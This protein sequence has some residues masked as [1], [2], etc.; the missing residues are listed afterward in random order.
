[1]NA[2]NWSRVLGPKGYRMSVALVGG[3]LVACTPPAMV[4][5]TA[6]APPTP[7]AVWQAP[8]D[9]VQPVPAPGRTS[10]FAAPAPLN[11]SKMGALLLGD[12]VELALSNSPQTRAS[13]AQARERLA[14]AAW[15][16]WAQARAASASYG[17]SRGRL[18]PSASFDVTGGPSQSV[19]QNPAR[20]P[21][22][23]TLTT[24]TLSL[25]Y[26][27][28]DFG[29]RGG[30]IGAA[31]EALYAAGLN[32]NAAVQSVVLQAEGAYFTY[33]S[34]R[35][36]LDAARA[37]VQ[38]AETNLA[39]AERRHDVG[40]ATIADVLQARTALAQSQLA[41]QTAEGNVQGARAQLALALGM[42]ANAAFDVAPDTAAIG[43]VTVAE[44]VDSLI[45]RAVRDRPDVAAAR[46]LARQSEQQIRVVRSASL[47][48]VTFGANSGKAMSNAPALEGRTLA[49]TLGL[50]VPLFNGV[51]RELDLVAAQ[52][53]FAAAVA[54]ADQARLQAV[55]QVFTSYWALRTA[56]Q[57]V[58]TAANLL[59]SA[60]QS[61]EVARG[62]YAEGVGSILDLL[63]AQNA[64][65]DA[66]AQAVQ[67]RWTWFTA[68]AQLSRDAG[69]LG[70]A[71]ETHL[72][73]TPAVPGSPE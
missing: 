55:A 15:S 59:A 25:Q 5:G 58:T 32:H 39:A 34:S 63:S 21:A 10:R 61:E 11:A 9:A 1:M 14:I 29:A 2:L 65:A 47:P 4:G 64:L 52:E 3:A 43:A 73:L 6:G 22:E 13:W 41:A 40:L 44:N 51:G 62:R 7:S 56:A 26:L 49:S 27:L 18:V 30:T 17:S 31:H 38:T 48:S 24:A 70:T 20:V 46:A 69:V 67:S 53:N 50:S 54:R 36:L 33:Q 57:R 19:S 23:R 66:R 16:T 35:G 60:T 12:I 37:T 42:P 28:W 8:R 71:G 45:E 72:K 68:L